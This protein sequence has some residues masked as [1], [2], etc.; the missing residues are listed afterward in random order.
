[1]TGLDIMTVFYILARETSA[2]TSLPVAEYPSLQNAAYQAVIA[3]IIPE[4]LLDRQMVPVAHTR[5]TARTSALILEVQDNT[6]LTVDTD[7][8]IY[9]TTRYDFVR[10][11]TKNVNGT[12]ITLE[13]PG[14]VCTLQTYGTEITSPKGSYVVPVSYKITP[15]R[16]NVTVNFRVCSDTVNTINEMDP[17]LDSDIFRLGRSFNE[18]NNP[19]KF[20]MVT[21]DEMKIYPAPNADGTIEIT[22]LDKSSY[23]LGITS[24]DDPDMLDVDSHM[25]I[26]YWLLAHNA[27]RE[28]DY[29]AYQTLFQIYVN[30]IMRSRAELQKKRSDGQAMTFKKGNLDGV[31]HNT[32]R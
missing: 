25:C 31:N 11:A 8:C 24:N 26:V 28:R 7:L 10:I 18:N 23:T 32:R 30:S 13:S 16:Y 19:Y 21:P 14:L 27:L 17:V 5:L 1:M 9:N 2:N 22:H 29:Q 3:D 6:V 15:T 20:C 4:A 12:T